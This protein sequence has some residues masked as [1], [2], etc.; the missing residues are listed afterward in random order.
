MFLLSVITFTLGL[1][2]YVQA[3]P[4]RR[5]SPVLY[6]GRAPSQ[7]TAEALDKSS[8]PYLTYVIRYIVP[9]NGSTREI[10]AQ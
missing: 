2:S 7:L 10:A 3:N 6:D 5:A 8:G 4:T 1:E 9:C